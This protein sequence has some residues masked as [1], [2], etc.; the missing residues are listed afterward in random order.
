MHFGALQHLTEKIVEKHAALRPTNIALESRA[1]RASDASPALT[2]EQINQLLEVH[3]LG[4]NLV[5]WMI[6]FKHSKGL[7]MLLEKGLDPSRAVDKAGGNNCLHFIARY[8][9]T[10]MADS[11][12][13]IGKCK[14]EGTNNAGETCAMVAAKA[15]NIPVARKLFALRAS[16]RRALDGGS[17]RAWVLAFVRR[18]EATEKSTQTGR[19]GEDDERWL[20]IAP[21]PSYIMW[22]GL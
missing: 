21:D 7:Q 16:A 22:Y 5:G 13:K 1:L 17:Y 4:V 9:T 14:L 6:K 10:S 20:S 12:L 19:T 11:V 2:I 8:G 18:Q 15:G 3:F